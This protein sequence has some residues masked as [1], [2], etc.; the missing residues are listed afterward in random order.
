MISK[1]FEAGTSFFPI[2]MLYYTYFYDPI[3]GYCTCGEAIRQVQKGVTK[4]SLSCICSNAIKFLGMSSEKFLNMSLEEEFLLAIHKRKKR[5]FPKGFVK[6]LCTDFIS[7]KGLLLYVFCTLNVMD[8]KQVSPNEFDVGIGYHYLNNIFDKSQKVQRHPG[9]VE[10]EEYSL[11]D[12]HWYIN[13]LN[14]VC[15]EHLKKNSSFF[16]EVVEVHIRE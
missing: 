2:N 5:R 4:I 3:Y 1:E 16:R 12:I 11:K 15:L 6:V 14:E 13:G 8:I 9:S 7:Y 10:G